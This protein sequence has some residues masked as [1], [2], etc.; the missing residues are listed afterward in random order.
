MVDIVNWLNTNQGFVMSLLTLV[1]VI[2]TIIIVAYNQKSIKEMQNTREEE[3]RPYIFAHLHKD[4]RDICFSFRVKNYGRTSGKIG[5]IEISP[6]LKFVGDQ[7]A[8]EFLNNVI[9]APNQMLQFI[10]IERYKETSRKTYDVTIK[11][12]STNNSKKTYNERY[13]LITQYSSKM[14]YTDHKSSNLPD[15]E[16]ALNNIANYL[17]SIRSKI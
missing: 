15:G 16:N 3:S 10:L 12:F 7:N 8:G 14:G 9:L 5:Y 4:P 1:Y 2:A 13:S 17:D 11:Y 6:Q